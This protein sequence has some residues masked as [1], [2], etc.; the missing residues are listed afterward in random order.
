MLATIHQSLFLQI[1]SVTNTIK[2]SWIIQ[3]GHKNDLVIMWCMC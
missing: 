1:E 3:F 2:L